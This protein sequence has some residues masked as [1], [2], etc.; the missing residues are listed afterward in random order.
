MPRIDYVDEKTISD[1][2]RALIKS[3][4]ETGTPKSR[5]VRIYTNS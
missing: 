5:C 3:A 4:D 2:A 1:E